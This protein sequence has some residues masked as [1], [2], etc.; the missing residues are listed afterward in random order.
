MFKIQF[1]RIFQLLITVNL[2]FI[3]SIPVTAVEVNDSVNKQNNNQSQPNKKQPKK[4]PQQKNP[5]S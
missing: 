1:H 3:S 2:A 4:P 5:H